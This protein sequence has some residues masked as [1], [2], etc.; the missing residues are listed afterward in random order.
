MDRPAW[1]GLVLRREARADRRFAV[2]G[3]HPE[4][5]PQGRTQGNTEPGQAASMRAMRRALHPHSVAR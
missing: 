2:V 4:L 1:S 3:A 5:A